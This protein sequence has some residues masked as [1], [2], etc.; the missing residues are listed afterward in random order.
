MNFRNAAADVLAILYLTFAAVRLLLIPISTLV[1][2]NT[3]LI[4]SSLTLLVST[5]I[6]SIWG[7]TNLLIM[8]VCTY[9]YITLTTI[10]TNERF[11]FK[12]TQLNSSWLVFD[13]PKMKLIPS[14]SCKRNET[15][16]K[17]L[18]FWLVCEVSW[19]AVEVLSPCRK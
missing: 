16:F 17:S 18:L 5:S 10:R 4:T 12:I 14:R 9:V 7:E 3:I 15:L 8:Q 1:S 13:S 6:L 2:S 11:L 19:L